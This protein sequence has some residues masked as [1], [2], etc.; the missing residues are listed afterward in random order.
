MKASEGRCSS[1]KPSPVYN[2]KPIPP[3]VLISS[4]CSVLQ[5]CQY[6]EVPG[7]TSALDCLSLVPFQSSFSIHRFNQPLLYFQADFF[8]YLLDV[9]STDSFTFYFSTLIIG[10][11][12]FQFS[13]HIWDWL[14]ESNM[15]LN[16][17]P[18][19]DG[20]VSL[21]PSS[22]LLHPLEMSG[23][24]HISTTKLLTDLSWPQYRHHRDIKGLGFFSFC[25]T[26]I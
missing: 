25:Q 24:V 2:R 11:V 26:C 20:I 16:I 17:A 15:A 8:P 6:S 7:K 9:R 12:P 23:A 13:M 22:S 18:N 3:Y 4:C 14:G 1:A 21:V 10:L 5:L 19:M